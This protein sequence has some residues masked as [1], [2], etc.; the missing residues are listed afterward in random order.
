MSRNTTLQVTE[1]HS[2]ET[3]KPGE[4]WST[5]KNAVFVLLFERA[6]AAYNYQIQHGQG[7]KDTNY[8]V[9]LQSFCNS[10]VMDI[11]KLTHVKFLESMSAALNKMF[12]KLSDLETIEGCIDLMKYVAAELGLSFTCDYLTMNGSTTQSEFNFTDYA[13][14][15]S[16]TR[17]RFI[18]DNKTYGHRYLAWQRL[19]EIGSN[20]PKTTITYALNAYNSATILFPNDDLEKLKVSM[21]KII[22][23]ILEKNSKL[24][25]ELASDENYIER[26][27]N[28][29]IDR[30]DLEML[31][32][33]LDF[34][35][36]A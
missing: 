8:K 25:K 33:T 9:G 10:W 31:S 11:T 4:L 6:L 27:T 12:A 34:N 35:R 2:N 21:H 17:L 15:S 20:N 1:F 7:T 18:A 23:E 16:I 14:T 30:D 26:L 13:A 24:A 36:F 32:F 22:Q 19:A 28:I 3:V 29:G 5:E